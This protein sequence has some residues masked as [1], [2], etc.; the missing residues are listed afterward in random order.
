MVFEYARQLSLGCT[1]L[2]NDRVIETLAGKKP[3][4]FA[5]LDK[6]AYFYD[7]PAVA[8]MLAK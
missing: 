8:R 1:C 3:L 7:N 2:H 5:I 4:T 6:H